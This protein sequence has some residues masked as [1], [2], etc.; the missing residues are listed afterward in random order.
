MASKSGVTKKRR[1]M[2]K[3]RHLTN[4]HRKVKTHAKKKKASTELLRSLEKKYL[5]KKK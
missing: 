3:K 2:R 5:K 1:G 4:R